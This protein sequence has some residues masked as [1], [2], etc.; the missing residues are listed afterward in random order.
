MLTWKSNNTFNN[1]ND[2]DVWKGFMVIKV[3]KYNSLDSS[4]DYA[5]CFVCLQVN[6]RYLCVG[7]VFG[8]LLVCSS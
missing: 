4:L 2:Q 7:V 3:D 6:A 8:V 5:L 1:G